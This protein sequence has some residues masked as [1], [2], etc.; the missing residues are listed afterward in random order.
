[1]AVTPLTKKSE[2]R[3]APRLTCTWVA[4]RGDGGRTRMEMRWVEQAAPRSTRS[5]A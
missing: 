1:M 4:V 5:A 3:P 2:A